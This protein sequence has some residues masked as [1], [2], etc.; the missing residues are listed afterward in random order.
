MYIR[1]PSYSSSKDT[2]LSNEESLPDVA[3]RRTSVSSDRPRRR[4]RKSSRARD[5]RTDREERREE[6]RDDRKDER[7]EGR[8]STAS[9]PASSKPSRTAAPVPSKPKVEI[10]TNVK[11]RPGRIQ[12]LSAKEEVVFK[13][14]WA[15]FLKYWG[16]DLKISAE[17]IAYKESFIASSIT[18]G[19]SDAN[20][21]RRADTTN[22]SINSTGTGASKKSKKSF[23]KSAPVKP[24]EVHA[25]AD[26][27]RLKEISQNSSSEVFEPVDAPTDSVINAYK[28]HYKL[29][30]VADGALLQDDVDDGASIES[31]VTAET[32]IETP[33]DFP[34]PSKKS[35]NSSSS[36]IVGSTT[37]NG[38]PVKSNPS[39]NADIARISAEEWQKAIIKGARQ[40]LIDNGFLRFVRARKWNTED[41]LKM[42]SNSIVWR[43][44][45]PTSDW[46]LEG[47]GPSYLQGKNK[48]L[49]K[50]L[51]SEKSWINGHDVD[52][53]PIY[54]FQARK[55]F[56]SDSPADESQ[57]YAILCIEWSRLFTK[58]VTESNDTHSIVFD[59]TGF[60]LKNA[61][62]STIKF[63]AEAFEAHYPECLGK[64]YVHN[65]PWIFSTVWNVI[66]H[67]LDP[68]VASKIEFTKNFNDLSK[69]ISAEF[70]PEELGGID[71]SGP[72]YPPPK[73]GDDV[74][75]KPHDATYQKLMVERDEIFMRLLSTTIKWVES[76]NP[77]ISSKYLTEKIRINIEFSNNYIELDPYI[78]NPGPYD[79]NGLISIR[80]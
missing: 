46:V 12:S 52:G 42:F 54:W 24:V 1:K 78:R 18:P 70:I 51:S 67:W 77:E 80:N 8:R 60:T 56:G 75:P 21:L 10:P 47:D 57:R 7:R 2:S 55:H 30:F 31:F 15:Y 16:Y 65:A 45:F 79:R 41:A 11:Y 37:A 50:N 63:L 69:H 27:P 43:K 73:K 3:T 26:S 74:P 64:I 19:A 40:D 49:I 25:P 62:Y 28:N 53:N 17:D 29:A 58:E 34:T 9:R 38:G 59:L 14:V 35:G 48:G 39:V 32:T 71:K 5:S 13:Q 66:K 44:D 20:S 68:V 33:D 22:S 36:G 76:T 6:R 4:D 23:F 72:E 61:D